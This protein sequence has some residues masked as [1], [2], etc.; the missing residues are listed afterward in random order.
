MPLNN[1]SGLYSFGAVKL[2]STPSVG[3][4]GQLLQRQQAKFDAMDQY[5]RGRLNSVNDKGVRDQ[6]RKKID[7]SL[8]QI[9]SFYN[10]NK[11]DIQKGNSQKAF[12]Y[13]KMFGGL[14]QLI[15]NSK[16]RAALTETGLKLTN[17][18]FKIDQRM[19]DDFMEAMHKNDLPIGEDG[20]EDLDILKWSSDAK[21]FD[22][23]K[24]VKEFTDLKR[25][26]K[27]TRYES[28][29]GQPLKQNEITE[30]VFDSGAKEVIAARAANKYENS[31]SFSETVKEKVADQ[32]QRKKLS[33]L[34][35]QEYGTS[36]IN[37]SDYAV[38]H[39]L[40]LLQPTVTKTKAID[41][42]DAIMTR[43]EN[44]RREQ[45]QRSHQNSLARL[46]VYANIKDRT[47]ENIGR[48]VDGL[49]SQHITD[50]RDNGGQ[51]LVDAETY[52]SITGQDKT[53]SSILMVD[54]TGNY[55][56]GRKNTEGA[57]VPSGN[58]PLDAAKIKL[59][60]TYK[61]GLDS[62][63]NTGNEKSTSTGSKYNIKGKEYTEK[64]LLD[65]GYTTEQIK[66]YKKN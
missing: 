14:K 34:F 36:P 66:P 31:H 22:Q 2:D 46:Y 35:Q 48:N 44:F 40:E 27:P 28:I 39:T 8:S 26:A 16:K 10:Q 23:N 47:P 43:Q 12:E 60:K 50:A 21:P 9:R 32:V 30:E 6:E 57:F 33:D 17:E 37:M 7:E 59:T 51:I 1:P 5:E 49:I 4:Y 11:K 58:I 54:E 65:M 29:A 13:E 55:T 52:K 56:Y 45:Q 53:G 25:T 19:P 24:F 3:L 42:K 20:S 62:R 41:N 18:R 38:A 63:Y 15:E 64:Q 61:S